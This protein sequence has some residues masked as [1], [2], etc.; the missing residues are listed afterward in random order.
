[1]D[2]E[3]FWKLLKPVHNQAAAFCQKL[4][5]DRERGNDLYQDGLLL[6]LRKFD[7]LKDLS[8][9]RGWLFRILINRYKNRCR[10]VWWQRR[11]DL[12]PEAIEN[13]RVDDP[14]DRLFW[15]RRL[16]QVLR[17][18][19]PEDR[20]LVVLHEVEGWSVPELAEM[21]SRPEGTIKTRLHRARGRMRQSLERR[22]PVPETDKTVS[23][24]AYALQRCKT[25]DE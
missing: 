14:R 2:N 5:G 3:L 6:A 23:E 21:F 10:S 8:A 18:L 9:F 19:T 20:A 1:M 16:T 4:T 7:S 17:V 12:T 24:V 25:A 22:A 13:A 11:V 15:R